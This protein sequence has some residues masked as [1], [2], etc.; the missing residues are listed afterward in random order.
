MEFLVVAYDGKDVG[1]KERRLKARPAHLEGAK[2]LQAADHLL[3]GGAI[4][5]D[6][7]EVIG[8][9]LYMDFPSRAE[10][11]QWLQTDPYTT[12]GVWRDI[13]VLPI[14]LAIR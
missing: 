9:T 6:A 12:G 1:A 4:L 2:V 10:L 5:D 11:D 13:Q 3:S 14:R 8:S 7:G